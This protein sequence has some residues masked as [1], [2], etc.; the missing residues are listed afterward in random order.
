MAAGCDYTMLNVQYR[1]DPHTYLL[2]AIEL[3]LLFLKLGERS[4]EVSRTLR[5][6]LR[7]QRGHAFT[8]L[9]RHANRHTPRRGGD[10]LPTGGGIRGTFGLRQSTSFGELVGGMEDVEYRARYDVELN[11]YWREYGGWTE[12][13]R[14]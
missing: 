13:S 4:G 5:H 2:Q 9:S 14:Y 8:P 3:T 7:S 10:H 1:M 12:A 6:G 11:R